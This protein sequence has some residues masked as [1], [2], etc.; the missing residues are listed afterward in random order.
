VLNEA[1]PLEDY[2]NTG[3][4]GSFVLYINT[5]ISQN[6][7]GVVFWTPANLAD[8]QVPSINW[9]SIAYNISIFSHIL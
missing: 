4:L 3:P 1:E 6:S 8:A 7:W 9:H 5:V 2:I